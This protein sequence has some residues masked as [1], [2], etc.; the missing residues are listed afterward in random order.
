MDSSSV[1]Y[2]YVDMISEEMIS[3]GGRQVTSSSVAS[4]NRNYVPYDAERMP[5]QLME[6]RF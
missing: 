6:M 4:S 3:E 5:V 2:E 1:E